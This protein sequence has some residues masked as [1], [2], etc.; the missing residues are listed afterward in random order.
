MPEQSELLLGCIADDFTGATDLANTLVRRGMRTVQA[1][2]VPHSA[3]KFGGAE[4]IVIALKSRTAPKAAAVSQSLAACRWLRDHGARQIYFKYCSTFDSTAE[5]NIGPVADA[6]LAELGADFA[7]ICPAFPETGRT[8][9][10]GH[11]FV[12]DVLLSDSHMRQHPLTPMTDSN[13]LRVL[14]RQTR[15]SMGLIAWDTV[16]QGVEAVKSAFHALRKKGVTYAVVDALEDANLLALGE[17]SA[18]LM[19]VTGGSGAALGLPENFRRAGLLLE[20]TAAEVLPQARG[21]AAVLSGSC[22]AA[23]LRQVD[24]M[25]AEYPAYRIDP[26]ALSRSRAA[27]IEQILSS[28]VPKLAETP[29]LI[30]ASASP[31]EVKAAQAMLG[32]DRAGSLVEAAMADIAKALVAAGVRRMVIAG[33]ETSGAV[34]RALKI[35]ALRIGGQIDPGIP[36]TV[37]TGDPTVAFALKSGNFGSEDFFLKALASLK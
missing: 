3:E 27:T 24:A 11:L 6:L 25:K 2:G 19:L 20:H 21:S 10:Q 9:Y 26:V 22:S 29:V 7:T 4:A 31:D 14:A 35:R 12:G 1:I 23:T 18:D 8:L 28:A 34:V 17:A 15:A 36:A 5:G 16:K 30:Y 13:L 32:A 37:S 33:G